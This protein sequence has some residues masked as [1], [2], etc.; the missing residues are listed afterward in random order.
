MPIRINSILFAVFCW[1]ILILRFGY[2]FGTGD[3]VELLPYTLFLDS[4]ILYPHDFFIQ[5]L[6][7][8]VP[9]ERTIMAN[10]LIPFVHHLEAA[11][12]V[13]HFLSTVLLILGLEKIGLRIVKS[14]FTVWV[15]I[16]VS[17]IVFND[18]TLGNVELQ[19]DCFQASL[20]SVAIVA[21]GIHFFLETKIVLSSVLMSMATF[22]QLLDGLDVMIVL[23]CI[24]AFQIISGKEKVKTIL[25]FTLPYACTAGLY[26][27]MI[28]IQ[29]QGSADITN[30]ELFEILFLF[31]HPHHFIF[32]SFPIVKTAVFLFFA[33]IALLRL[34]AIS[35][36]LWLFAAIAIVGSFIYAI[37]VDVM[38]NI[39]IA[40]FQF[41]KLSPWVKFLGVVCFLATLEHLLLRYC[42]RYIYQLQKST[43]LLLSIVTVFLIILS[44]RQ[45][46]PYHV[47]FQLPFLSYKDDLL[48]ACD[49]IKSNTPSDAV[50]IQD[51][52]N[53]ELKFYAQRSSYVEFKA[54][55]RHKSKVREWFLRINEVYF[56]DGLPETKGFNLRVQ[57]QQNFLF[58]SNERLQL[59]KS[60]GVTH[61]LRS[62]KEK[63]VIHT[64]AKKIFTNS[65]YAVYQL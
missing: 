32:S 46:L 50:F 21:W 63:T 12:F 56:P 28:F 60:K 53:T 5:G 24:L 38:H 31:R 51:F 25:L 48:Q 26:L 15:A 44:G 8:S 9:N 54:N 55:V 41:Y 45:F 10:L 34:K 62:E 7:A 40:N 4:P 16:L 33:S 1:A 52:D 23:C 19:S 61:M 30:E 43:S 17:L 27:V 29:K 49:W 64:T 22:F 36:P 11:C 59:L 42:E 13:L 57:G 37:S 6:N 58:I 65:G 20:L 39:F 47:P 3:Q 14:R 2:R 18:Y 35:K